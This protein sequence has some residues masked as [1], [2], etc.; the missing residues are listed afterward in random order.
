MRVI[1]MGTPHFA[2]PALQALIDSPHEIVA[3]YS[4]PPRPSGRGMKLTA[5]P[6]HQL[7]ES[8]GIP[9]RTPLNFKSVDDQ[10]TFA[11]YH[12]DIAV[13]AAYGLLLPQAILAA[14]HLGCINIH[15]S[16][17]PRWRGAA[18]IQRTLLA[19]D[20]RTACCIIQLE[21]GLDTGPIHRRDGYAIPSTMNAG[22]LMDTMAA[23][24]AEQV[25]TVLEKLSAANPPKPILQSAEGITYAQKITKADR[26][27]DWSQPAPELLAQIRGLAPMPAALVRLNDEDIKLFAATVETG[28]ASQPV[29]IA[30][31]DQLLINCGNGTALR[32][33][34][35]QRPGKTRASATQF[36]QGFAV[37]SGSP[38]QKIGS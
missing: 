15:P 13:V 10:K 36:L 31:D 28:D 23:L 22:E 27:L 3:V 17:L 34:E 16:D 20:R 2:V 8:H 4:Q 38:A 6:V 32:L 30:L 9:V 25:L 24:G 21:L 5:S 7:A 1:F 26:I 35:L 37:A 18:P 29:G 33:V 14:P 12:A 11:D 19:G